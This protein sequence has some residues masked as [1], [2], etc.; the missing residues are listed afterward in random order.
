MSYV[1]LEMKKHHFQPILGVLDT[2]LAD[3]HQELRQELVLT[4]LGLKP[5]FK[6]EFSLFFSF[7]LS[8]S[9]I[10]PLTGISGGF[11]AAWN[12]SGP[13]A[14]IYGWK[15]VS[16][17]SMCIALSMAEI[18]SGLPSSGGPFFWSSWLGG[19]HG[20]LLSWITGWFNMLGQVALTAGIA[21]CGMFL[22]ACM[23]QL[24]LGVTMSQLQQLAVYLGILLIGGAA[25]SFS[26]KVLTYF[27]AFG[28]FINI[29]G[30]I[31]LVLLLSA[32]APWRESPK[33]VWATFFGKDMSPNHVP[34]DVYL[35]CQG[36]V[37]AAFVFTGYDSSSHIS[38]ETKGADSSAPYAICYSVA[39][40]A[41]VGYVLLLGMIF[42]VQDP[43]DLTS[44][45]AAAGGYAAGQ[46]IFDIFRNRF[47]PGLGSSSGSAAALGVFLLASIM[48]T[49]ASLTANSRMIYA[50]A[51]D[52]GLPF[53]PFFRRVSPRLHIPMR[54]LWLSVT[55]AF[56]LGLPLLKSTV[57]FIAVVSISSLGLTISYGIPIYFAYITL[58]TVNFSLPTTYPV[59]LQSF[60]YTPVAVGLVL[61]GGLISWFFPIFGARHW[62]TGPKLAFDQASRTKLQ[63][64]NNLKSKSR[65]FHATV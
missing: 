24:L 43:W 25:N 52:G 44:P 16:F 65:R 21:S 19:K 39:A 31:F 60:N 36:V 20:P 2:G 59:T 3:D 54:T 51:R 45:E 32:V 58:C 34:D 28:T 35:W 11:S 53:S 38:E 56:V 10:S 62:Y 40:S 50:F 37:M 46:L 47:G 7:G 1:V 13:A 9:I 26:P 64:L 41:V 4:R 55:C 6:R 30:V 22:V 23:V 42:N 8:F 57:A 61:L 15:L 29:A 18:V 33:F 14:A 48:C 49:I 5:E 63:R 27:I 12:N 17:F